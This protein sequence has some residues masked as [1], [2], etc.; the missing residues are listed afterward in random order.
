M[1]KYSDMHKTQ[2]LTSVSLCND[3]CEVVA[4]LKLWTHTEAVHGEHGPIGGFHDDVIVH[5]HDDH[6]LTLEPVTGVEPDRKIKHPTWE[7]NLV[8][9]ESNTMGKNCS[10]FLKLRSLTDSPV[11]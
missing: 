6:V 10:S 1:S 4:L 9:N 8:S 7:W 5:R 11:A 2:P 3:Q